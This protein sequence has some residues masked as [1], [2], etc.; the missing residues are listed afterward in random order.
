MTEDEL[1]YSIALIMVPGIG[2]INARKLIAFTG[3]AK[4]VFKEKKQQLLHI[5]GIGGAVVSELSN[6]E[7]LIKAEAELSFLKKNN[8]TAALCTD[9]N[10]PERLRNCPDAPFLLFVKG[11]CNLN[12]RK[13]ISIVGTRRATEYGRELCNQVIATL[14]ERKHD[15]LI[16]S[17][18]AYGIDVFAHKAC[19]KHHLPTVGVLAHGLS[20]IYPAAHRIVAHEMCQSGGALIT[21][22]VSNEKP[23]RPNFVRR[24]RVIAGLADATIV[25]ESPLQSGALITAEMANSYNRDV[26]AFPGRT[27]DVYSQGC[28]KLIKSNKANLVENVDDIEYLLGWTKSDKKSVQTSLFVELEPDEQKLYSL[29]QEHGELFIDQICTLSDLPVSTVSAKLLN[30][31]FSGL[32]KCFP[33]KLF[34][35]S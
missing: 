24:N 26:F 20:M 25:V 21:E 31:E 32:I 10:Y 11:N 12:N 8:I 35:P 4:A 15:V 16:I 5:Q 29:L 3:S 28:N 27:G 7:T 1:L 6:K 14:A 33:G 9:K 13:I 34:R 23:D 30:L 2:D 19:L 22:F 17:G 18:L